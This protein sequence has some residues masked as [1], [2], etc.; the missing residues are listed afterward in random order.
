M[1]EPIGATPTSIV[2]NPFD[3]DQLVVALWHVG[4]VVT[5]P[6]SGEGEVVDLLTGI[7]RP[8]HLLVDGAALLVSDHA[9]GTIWRRARRRLNTERPGAARAHGRLREIRA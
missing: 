4:R 9:A 5:A 2:V 1:F 3:A 8:Q 7:E 6:I